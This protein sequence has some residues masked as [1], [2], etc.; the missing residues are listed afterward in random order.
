M[1]CLMRC[2]RIHH[3]RKTRCSMRR[4]AVKDACDRQAA[5][6]TL[7]Q[8]MDMPCNLLN[9]VMRRR[10]LTCSKHDASCQ[11]ACR[12]CADRR[13]SSTREAAPCRKASESCLMSCTR[14]AAY[15]AWQRPRNFCSWRA[16]RGTTWR[17][18][19]AQR[20][21]PCMPRRRTHRDVHE[22]MRSNWRFQRPAA[23]NARTAS[24][25]CWPT[26]LR[27][28]ACSA[29]APRRTLA[30]SRAAAVIALRSCSSRLRRAQR[31]AV[32]HQVRD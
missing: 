7:K 4:S 8:R 24:R 10:R 11:V 1:R 22:P 28:K 12:C 19:S 30:R 3:A 2:C 31:A 15:A 29:A 23:T 27:D 5:S 9:T 21:R 20:R 17:S 18:A 13:S 26:I 32:L 14:L 25:C 6:A 16:R